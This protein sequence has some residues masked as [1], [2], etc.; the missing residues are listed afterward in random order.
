V[1]F[2]GCSAHCKRGRHICAND[3][4]M[5]IE[6]I[7][8]A[9]LRTLFGD[10]LRPEGVAAMDRLFSGIAVSPFVASPTGPLDT[11][12]ELPIVGDTRRAA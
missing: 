10:V 2:Y 8:A 7:D 12:Y 6:T 9:V 11:Y 1:F 4:V 5:R 3:Y